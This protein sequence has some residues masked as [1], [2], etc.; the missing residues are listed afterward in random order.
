ML[1]GQTPINLMN[2]KQGIDELKGLLERISQ[3]DL[4]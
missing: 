3:G 4:S 2:N 1:R